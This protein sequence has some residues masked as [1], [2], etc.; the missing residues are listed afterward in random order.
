M[1]TI[2]GARAL[3]LADDI[4]SIEVGKRADVIIVD[5]NQLHAAPEADVVSSLV[6]S[7]QAADVRATIV[8]GRVLM[9]ERALTTMN[10]AEVIAEANREAKALSERANLDPSV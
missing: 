7:T 6:Y 10:E 8:D 3:G 4:G 9:R 2:D 5:L 1:A